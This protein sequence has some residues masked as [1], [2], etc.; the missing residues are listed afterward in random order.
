MASAGTKA[1]KGPK[2]SHS[3]RVHDDIWAAANRRAQSEGTTVN[4]VVEEI[5]EGYGRGLINL[6]KIV[7]TYV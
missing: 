1:G 2:R 5:L 4:G 3:V 6:P 7:K